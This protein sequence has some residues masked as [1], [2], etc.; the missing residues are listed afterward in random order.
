MRLVPKL[1]ERSRKKVGERGRRGALKEQK[2]SKGKDAGC[3]SLSGARVNV[4]T[5]FISVHSSVC[6]CTQRT[7]SKT[8]RLCRPVTSQPILPPPAPTSLLVFPSPPLVDEK[9]GVPG[10]A[11]WFGGGR[12]GR[13]SPLLPRQAELL[14]LL[15]L[16]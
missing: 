1:S 14:T 10:R 3:T 11:S 7:F 12:G 9:I 16:K 5:L 4:S 13:P 8:P 15:D 6:C 2:G